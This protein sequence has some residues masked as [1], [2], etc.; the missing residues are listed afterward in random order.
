MNRTTVQKPSLEGMNVKDA[1]D[2]TG[3]GNTFCGGFLVG[4]YRTRDLLTAALWGSVSASFSKPLISN[5]LLLCEPPI[6]CASYY[7]S[8]VHNLSII[9]GCVG[10]EWDSFFLIQGEQNVGPFQQRQSGFKLLMATYFIYCKGGVF[11][12]IRS[13][14]PKPDCSVGVRRHSSTSSL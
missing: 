5:L 6:F 10:V 9:F 11:G 7:S 8:S 4:W 14:T 2:P 3:C 12:D 13:L 1:L